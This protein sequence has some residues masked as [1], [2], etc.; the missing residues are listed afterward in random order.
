MK[1]FAGVKKKWVL[2]ITVYILISNMIFSV[3]AKENADYDVRN[4]LTAGYILDDKLYAFFKAS[5]SAE[6]GL[7]IGDVIY[8]EEY[9]E[10]LAESNQYVHYCILLDASGSVRKSRDQI[11]EFVMKL[12][13]ET[14]TKKLV[15]IMTL[16]ESFDEVIAASMEDDA[17][18][19]ALN[20]IS[21]S[22][23]ITKLYK[24]IDSAIRYID[25]K[26]RAR[27]DLYRLILVTD[28]ESDGETDT[29]SPEEIKKQI[30]SRTDIIFDV[31]GIGNWKNDNEKNMPMTGRSIHI[32]SSLEQAG[33]AASKLAAETDGLYTVCFK[34]ADPIQDNLQD[35][36]IFLKGNEKRIL[37]QQSLT[38]IGKRTLHDIPEGELESKPT[39]SAEKSTDDT[40]SEQ[41]STGD[42]AKT[43]PESEDGSTKSIQ[44][45]ETDTAAAENTFQ[46]KIMKNLPVYGCAVLGGIVVCIAVILILK[47]LFRRKEKI[48]PNHL[49]VEVLS[50]NYIS[51]KKDFSLEHTLIIGSEKNCDIIWKEADVAGQNTRIFLNEG[52]VYIEDLNSPCGTIIG[53][54][55]LFSPNRLRSGDVVCIGNHVQFR[56]FFNQNDALLSRT[57]I[58]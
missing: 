23:Q 1:R 38:V 52:I 20:G 51:R 31:I 40:T 19:K 58:E 50:G 3:Y 35:I 39:E 34:L 46:Q 29:P 53:G 41:E 17:V 5:E 49:R 26:E 57:K 6:A 45:S 44:K 11:K 43:E 13:E 47:K 10:A 42:N 27:G 25:E 22:D 37:E 7:L 55:R 14:K 48:A 16:G 33:D 8:T 21:Y 30:E 12:M 32:V 15:T 36:R 18:E 4:S 9:T 28:G 24:G 2:W 56:V 54:M